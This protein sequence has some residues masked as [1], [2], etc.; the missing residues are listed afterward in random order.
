MSTAHIVLQ[1]THPASK[2]ALLYLVLSITQHPPVHHPSDPPPHLTYQPTPGH[3]HRYTT[4]RH[5][6]RLGFS[7]TT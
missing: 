7:F 1:A 3:Y 6:A 5:H 4:L 2:S